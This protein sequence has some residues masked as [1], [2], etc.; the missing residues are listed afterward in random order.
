MPLFHCSECG[1]EVDY[2]ARDEYF[3]ADR[4]WQCM[5]CYLVIAKRKYPTLPNAQTYFAMSTEFNRLGDRIWINTIF[6]YYRQQNPTE[7][8]ILTTTE[9]LSHLLEGRLHY[10]KLFWPNML[11]HNFIPRDPTHPDRLAKNV[12]L[13]NVA[14]ELT[15]LVE[16]CGL[17]LNPGFQPQPPAE[18]P[19]QPYIVFHLRAYD[20]PEKNV[21]FEELFRI[22]QVLR[23][24]QNEFKSIVL[25]GNDHPVFTDN[26][27]LEI[28]PPFIDL[29]NRASLPE[30]LWLIAN[31]KLYLG[32]DSGI[33][34]L[35]ACTDVKI[36]AWNFESPDWFPKA[37]PDNLTVACKQEP[38]SKF[39]TKL[40]SAL[41]SPTK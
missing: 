28:W 41:K 7:T 13:F 10:D 9:Q 35:A 32:K 23:R 37:N 6:E 11:N 27:L 24:C 15:D 33:T 36:A 21:T 5:Q 26:D 12:F 39:L 8:V 4:C 17:K 30:I 2:P 19:P 40:F 20:M 31:A 18:I 22:L 16:H 25:V 14:A 34:Q 3:Y 38:F 1:K 29:R